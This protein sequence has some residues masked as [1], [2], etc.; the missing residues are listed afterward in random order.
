MVCSRAAVPNISSIYE[1]R[2]KKQS[3]VLS[4]PGQSRK[5]GA[6]IGIGP[7]FLLRFEI[8]PISRFVRSIKVKADVEVH[9]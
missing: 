2:G 5:F 7:A 8:V 9:F 6:F 1:T 4:E 3:G